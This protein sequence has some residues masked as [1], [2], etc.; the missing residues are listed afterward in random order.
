MYIYLD[1]ETGKELFSDAYKL[2]EGESKATFEIQSWKC[3]PANADNVDT[4][5]NASEEEQAEELD[6]NTEK[7]NVMIYNYKYTAFSFDFNQIRDYVRKIGKRV[8]SEEPER[9]PDVEEKLRKFLKEVKSNIKKEPDYYD[10]Y[11]GEECEG[12]PILSYFPEGAECP[13]FIYF[14]DGCIKEKC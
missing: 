5:A 1:F 12:M 11:M 2:E 14:K 6:E 8:K 3:D 13:K 7:V 10:V 9:F 4:G